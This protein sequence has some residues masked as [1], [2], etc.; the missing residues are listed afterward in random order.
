MVVIALSSGM[1]RGEILELRWSDVDLEWKQI[2]L[3]RTKNRERRRIPISDE[4]LEA[5][6]KLPRHVDTKLLFPGRRKRNQP[7]TFRWR[8]KRR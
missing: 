3:Q 7:R 6:R 5:L 2:T 1:G 8:S 4:L